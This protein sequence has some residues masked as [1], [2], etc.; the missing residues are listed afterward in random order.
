MIKELNA[1]KQNKDLYQLDMHKTEG[2]PYAM[3]YSE[4]NKFAGKRIPLHWHKE[5]AA[6]AVIKG[7]VKAHINTLGDKQQIALKEGEGIFINE[8]VIHGFT[9]EDENAVLLMI[10]FD[11]TLISGGYESVLSKRYLDPIRE[12]QK[13]KLVVL[14]GK[15]EWHLENAAI[16]SEIY[17]AIGEQ[18][19]WYEFI[20]REKITKFM[21][22]IVGNM[23]VFCGCLNHGCMI[24]DEI[25]QTMMAY[26]NSHYQDKMTVQDIAGS[27]NISN[28]DCYRRFNKCLSTTPSEYLKNIRMKKAMELLDESDKTVTE[29]SSAVGFGNSSYFS[30]L[31]RELMHC[32]PS[33]YRDEKMR[34]AE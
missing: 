11:L 5:A 33:K 4:I 20:V 17:Q 12:N 31:F 2:M 30:K 10:V 21:M 16:L 25:M 34:L 24:H 32:T 19:F 15:Q 14:N 18:S 3:Y 7:S 9:T 23:K 1:I 29:I 13:L 6:C 27:A 28:R 22:N 8:N 26:I